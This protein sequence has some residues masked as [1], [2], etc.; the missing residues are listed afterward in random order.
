MASTRR[1]TVK[2]RSSKP[3]WRK[4]KA[5]RRSGKNS[6]AAALRDCNAA[7]AA[8]AVANAMRGGTTK[9]IELPPQAVAQMAGLVAAFVAGVKKGFACAASQDALD[10]INDTLDNYGSVLSKQDKADLKQQGD[11]TWAGMVALGCMG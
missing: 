5:A 11:E 6:S 10:K 2:R 3:A 9:P 1:P 4:A 7:L 8:V